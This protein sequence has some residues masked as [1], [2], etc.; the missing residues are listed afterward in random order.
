MDPTRIEAAVRLLCASR[1]DIAAVYLH[2]SQARGTARATSD[3]DVAV[4]YR[5][6]PP[7]GLAALSLG[8]EAA[9]ERELGSPVQAITL[10][11]ASPELA[12]RVLCDGYLLLERDASA[13]VRFEVRVRNEY[14]DLKPYLDEYRRAPA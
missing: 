7:P 9:L 12:H 13:R 6:A 10:N 4:L 8:L 5:E 11:T 1:D 2:G 3:V 14:F